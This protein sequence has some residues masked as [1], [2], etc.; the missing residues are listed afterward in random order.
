MELKDL[1]VSNVKITSKININEKS[2]R[3]ILKEKN[4]ERKI[5]KSGRPKKL[6]LR[7]KKQVLRTFENG[8][9]ENTTN[10]VEFVKKIWKKNVDNSTIRRLITKNGMKSYKKHV[11]HPFL[12]KLVS[13]KCFYEKC[14]NFN[15]QIFKKLYFR[16]SPLLYY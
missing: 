2:V 11:N 5:S 16:M 6:S 12:K 9:L 14:K 15:F 13:R 3:R 8:N 4:F 1:G 10:G 7:E